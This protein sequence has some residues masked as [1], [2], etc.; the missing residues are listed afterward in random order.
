M[1]ERDVPRPEREDADALGYLSGRIVGGVDERGQTGE[2][3]LDVRAEQAAGVEVGE[4]VLHGE[5]GVDFFGR[6]PEAGQFVRAG[7]GLREVLEA[8]AARHAVMDDRC[9]ESV[10]QVGEVTSERCARDFEC[11]Q[12]V[13]E[14]DDAAVVE[15]LVDSV[16]AFQLAHGSPFVLMARCRACYS[17]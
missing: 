7:G 4:Q 11:V 13:V 15:Q 14:A 5:Q 16:G 17:V 9:V 6:E 1:F 2:Q 12:Q 8:V 10:A 3:G